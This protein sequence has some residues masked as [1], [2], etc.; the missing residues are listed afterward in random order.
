MPPL[1]LHTQQSASTSLL[2]EGGICLRAVHDGDTAKHGAGS[3]EAR[4]AFAG[5]FISRWRAGRVRGATGGTSLEVRDGVAGNAGL[6]VV[7]GLAGSARVAA[8]FVGASEDEE[9]FLTKDENICLFFLLCPNNFFF[10]Q[11]ENFFVELVLPLGDGSISG[12]GRDD[13]GVGCT[14]KSSSNA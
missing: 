2:H 3:V 9:F 14:A 10:S 5:E 7:A 8:G 12:F 6:R 13:D 1:L 11:D 4:V